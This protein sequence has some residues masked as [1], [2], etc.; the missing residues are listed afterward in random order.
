VGR[1]RI[2]QPTGHRRGLDFH[3]HRHAH[4]RAGCRQRYTA[5]DRQPD[6][7]I[8]PISHPPDVAHLDGTCASLPFVHAN[9]RSGDRNA[10]TDQDAQAH[11]NAMD[12]VVTRGFAA[13][14]TFG[15]AAAGGGQRLGYALPGQP[16]LHA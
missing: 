4:G 1:S 8:H 13:T 12:D 3:A 14:G 10:Q 7:L 5:G 9:G 2:Y 15:L 11:P 6:A 16:I